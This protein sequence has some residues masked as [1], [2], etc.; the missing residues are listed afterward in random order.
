MN[1]HFIG[2]IVATLCL[3]GVLNG[4]YG[5]KMD[6]TLDKALLSGGRE[7]ALNNWKNMQWS[8]DSPHLIYSKTGPYIYRYN[9]KKLVT[10][11]F[12]IMEPLNVALEAANFKTIREIPEFKLDKGD[13]ITFTLM[14]TPMNFDLKSSHLIIKNVRPQQGTNI[15]YH[16]PSDQ[17]AF[18]RDHGLWIRKADGQESL[19]ALGSDSIVYGE[20]VHRQE[21]GIMSGTFWSPSGKYLAFYRMDQSMV[22]KYPVVDFGSTPAV[23]NDIYYPMAG[24]KSHHVRVGIYNTLTGTAELLD[25]GGDPEHYLTNITWSPDESEIYIAEIN[26]DQNHTSFN[27]YD[28]L[29]GRKVRT[30]FEETHSKYTEPLEP[31]H[32]LPED[33]D[34]FILI[35]KRSGWNS[36]YL[37]HRNGELI[38]QLSQEV[39]ISGPLKFDSKNKIVYFHGILPNS[40]DLQLFKSEIGTGKLTQVTYGPGVHQTAISFDG[41]YFLDRHIS[42]TDK[43]TYSVSD[44]N[45]KNS[46]KLHQSNEPLDNYK[47]GQTILDTLTAKDGTR[48]FARTILPYDFDANKKYPVVIYVYGG[49]H[50]QMIRNTRLAQAQMWMHVLANEGFV[51]FTLDNR[52]SSN[53]GMAFENAVFRNLGDLEME[54]QMTGYD[55]LTGK[56]YVDENRI[57]VHGWSYGGF[58]T[59]SLMTRQPGKFHAAVAGGPVTDWDMYE[60]MYT[61]RYMDTP[62][63]NPEGYHKSSTFNHIDQLAGPM[64]LIH[65]TSDDVVLWQ[66]SLKYIKACV[67]K[68]KQVEYFVYPGH[69]HNVLG[70]DRVHLIQK[71]ID[72]FKMHL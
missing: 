14:G 23:A 1:K 59:I 8:T 21:F 2:P 45:M 72:Y 55:F 48:L 22:T 20:A 19:I 68:G 65:G 39:E 36:L 10:D 16:A 26:R 64:L 63:Q 57:G 13:K 3:L 47:I 38:R 5:Q 44:G 4:L 31:F 27:A 56:T 37:Y 50:A 11:S 15:D 49:P 53:R 54:D 43:L 58:M 34:K 9:A 70:K 46:R 69:A 6:L 40:I 25:T 71:V 51:V 33:G 24:S 60:V 52:G 32:F 62:D 29:N 41:A 12:N 18:T 67:D 28:V 30:L 42:S 66:H 61:E 17:Y 7:L 35:S